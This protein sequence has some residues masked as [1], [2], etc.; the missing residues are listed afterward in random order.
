MRFV[1]APS[2][3]SGP[4]ANDPN[5]VSQN[6]YIPHVYGRHEAS[7]VITIEAQGKT[8]SRLSTRGA[9]L[10]YRADSGL[11]VPSSAPLVWRVCGFGPQSPSDS[12]PKTVSQPPLSTTTRRGAR[13]SAQRREP[14]HSAHI[15][16]GR[17]RTLCSCRARS[18]C[19]PRLNSDGRIT[20]ECL[21]PPS[22]RRANFRRF[23]DN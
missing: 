22:C 10:G 3:R 6:S 16:L 9:A 12:L 21:L 17:G 8:N 13:S 20:H 23:M 11:I 4:L 14:A 5:K 19:I 7:L 18:F 15:V 2:D 1:C